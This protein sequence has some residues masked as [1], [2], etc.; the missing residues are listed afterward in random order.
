MKNKLIRLLKAIGITT[1][2]FGVVFLFIWGFIKYPLITN[3]VLLI[4]LFI[5]VVWRIYDG[6]FDSK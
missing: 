5:F 2:C 3:V 4:L 6:D 1:I